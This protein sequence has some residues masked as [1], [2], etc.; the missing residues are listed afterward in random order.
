MDAVIIDRKTYE[1]LISFLNTFAKQVKELCG[2][3]QNIN[4]QWLDNQDICQLLSISKRTLQYY[5]DT[6]IIPF[7]QIGNKCYYRA[8]DIEELLNKSEIKQEPWK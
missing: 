4:H 6:N 2:G 7:S 8:S 1:E 3:H 5:R